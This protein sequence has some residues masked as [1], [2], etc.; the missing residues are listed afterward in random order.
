MQNKLKFVFLLLAMVFISVSFTGAYFSDNITTSGNTFAV[1]N[2]SNADIIINEFVPNPTGT[3]NASM[4]DGEWI[5]LYN[6]GN[7]A[8]NVDGWVLDA[9]AAGILINPSI[10][11]TG[12][13]AIAPGGYLVVYRNGSPAIEL[14]NSGDTVNLRLT[15][16]GIV[17][18]NFTYTSI[19][20]N[21]SWARVPN[22][23]SNWIIANPTKG[24]P[25]V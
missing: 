4:P 12:T 6:K 10:T 14:V 7:W 2:S 20:E 16:G 5:E 22:A 11:N 3:D 21:K 13:T 15:S 8:I 1:G 19:G 18:D 24:G 9:G 25:N 23:G 17:I